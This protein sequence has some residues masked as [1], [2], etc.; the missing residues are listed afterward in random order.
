MMTL[1][2][3]LVLKPELCIL[4]LLVSGYLKHALVA[5]KVKVKVIVRGLM[6]LLASASK[7]LGHATL[8][9]SQL[10]SWLRYP[11]N[12]L[13]FPNAHGTHKKNMVVASFILSEKERLLGYMYL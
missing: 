12:A 1:V 3:P 4:R 7:S 9:N 13:C 5:L 8:K 10:H 11:I 2:Y 6:G